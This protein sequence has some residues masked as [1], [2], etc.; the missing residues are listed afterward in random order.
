MKKNWLGVKKQWM[1]ELTDEMD[2]GRQMDDW[3]REWNNLTNKKNRMNLHV[4]PIVFLGMHPAGIQMSLPIQIQPKTFVE[5]KKGM[6][7]LVND[8]M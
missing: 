2:E 4:S 8:T 5:G 3:L 6:G 1:F 7:G